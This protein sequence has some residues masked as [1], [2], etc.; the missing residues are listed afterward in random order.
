MPG[1][2]PST[3]MRCDVSTG[4]FPSSGCASGFTTRPMSASPTGTERTRP[5]RLTVSPSRDVEVVAEDDDADGV[6]F[7]VQREAEG[8][9]LELHHLRGHDLL[10]AVDPG[11][12][13]TDLEDGADLVDVEVDVEGLDLLADDRA[14]LVGPDLRHGFLSL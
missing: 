10:E 2:R 11:D 4:P 12:A 6:L 8:P 14:D 1:A 5:V 9:V 13:V 7:E 3:G